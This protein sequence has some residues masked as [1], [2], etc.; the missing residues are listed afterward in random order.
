MKKKDGKYQWTF[1]HNMG[2]INPT[3]MPSIKFEDLPE[4]EQLRLRPD[5]FEV[6]LIDDDGNHIFTQDKDGNLKGFDV[7]IVKPP[8]C[9]TS[10]KIEFE[11]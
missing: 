2:G 11:L 8:K 9:E 6:I 4:I 10:F 1:E 3:I 5:L 7:E